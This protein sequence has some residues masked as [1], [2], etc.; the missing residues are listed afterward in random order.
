MFSLFI[1]V[2]HTYVGFC[3]LPNPLAFFLQICVAGC[4]L[5]LGIVAAIC[6]G[7]ARGSAILA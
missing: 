4:I 5:S 3:Y 7:W 6:I 1:I 2:F